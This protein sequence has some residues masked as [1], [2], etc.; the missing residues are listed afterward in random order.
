MTA[1]RQKVYI[2][3]PM[4]G[5]ASYNVLAFMSAAF[6]WRTR[7]YVVET[8]FEANSRVWKKHYGR[9]F[10]PHMDKCDY[11]DAILDEMTAEDMAVLCAADI[12]ALLPGWEKSKGCTAE[13]LV[14]LNLR[15]EIRCAKTFSTLYLESTVSITHRP[16]VA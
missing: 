6:I 14:A 5:R 1:R 10:N 3:G 11:G 16:K 8:P 15:K 13:L 7:G 2:A 4:T 12:I 9:N